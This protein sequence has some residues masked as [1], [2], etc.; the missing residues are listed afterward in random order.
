[1]KS[2]YFFYH[3]QSVCV[4]MNCVQ[5]V[6]RMVHMNNRGGYR[7]SARSVKD[8]SPLDEIVMWASDGANEWHMG[9]VRLGQISQN[10]SVLLLSISLL[11]SFS[12]SFV[13]MIFQ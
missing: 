8:T 6:G 4:G 2:A 9:T 5:S 12:D 3:V 11:T 1:M 7:S 10:I 13:P